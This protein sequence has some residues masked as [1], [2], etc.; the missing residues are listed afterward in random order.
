M[1]KETL[2]Y[3]RVNMVLIRM[4]R[5]SWCIFG[6][7]GT[8]N[9]T[10][11]HFL[12]SEIIPPSR[13]NLVW[14]IFRCLLIFVVFMAVKVQVCF[15]GYPGDEG[16]RLLWYI[17]DHLHDCTLSNPDD[18]NVRVCSTLQVAFERILFDRPQECPLQ[19]AAISTVV[20][21]ATVL[22]Q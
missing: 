10:C 19:S 5:L 13:L 2:C 12:N 8:E 9:K 4:G 7:V 21:S 15:P 18:Q 6:N 3:T 17:A 11:R 16:S 1:E 20:K 14:N 22:S